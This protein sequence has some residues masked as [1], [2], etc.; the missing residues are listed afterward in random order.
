MENNQEHK[1][2]KIFKNS[3]ENQSVVP[4]ADAWMAIQTYTIGQEESKKRILL[5]YA[6][7]TLLLLLFSGLGLWYYVEN[8]A[9]K[10]LF[11]NTR[12]TIKKNKELSVKTHITTDNNNAS[13]SSLRKHTTVSKIKKSTNL[14][15][16]FRNLNSNN[17]PSLSSLSHE[18]LVE[19]TNNGRKVNLKRPIERE[20]L[21]IEIEDDSTMYGKEEFVYPVAIYYPIG[22]S[23]LET[24]KPK[25][26][27]LNNLSDKIQ[28]ESE[29]KVVALEENLVDKKEIS[30]RDS[31]DFGN[32][33]SLK[34]P[35]ITLGFGNTF[36]FWKINQYFSGS[37]SFFKP[38]NYLYY[39]ENDET[40]IR[41]GVSWKLSKKA[42]FGFIISS[43]KITLKMPFVPQ[44]IFSSSVGSVQPI[45]NLVALNSD[46]FYQSNTV[47]G[48]V[49]IPI[50]Y[51]K[52][53]PTVVPN[54]LDE[55][56]D[57]FPF[58]SHIMTI[59]SLSLT[60]QYD[61]ISKNRKKGK[62]RGYQLYG[63]A[64][65]QVQRQTGYLYSAYNSLYSPSSFYPPI[66][67]SIPLKFSLELNHLENASELVFGLRAGLGFRYQFARKWDFHVEGSGQHSLNNW[68]KSDDIKTFQ[69]ALS[70]QA[71]IN[72]NL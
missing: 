10:E 23:D 11:V 44:P 26:L 65:F 49:N 19:N 4:P 59:T 67:P 46:S 62:R 43:N 41:I 48:D 5:R 36:N 51:F 68:V 20:P 27:A 38:S 57:V 53:L 1:I 14:N 45:A 8:Q 54:K 16:E 18:L 28:K 71:G 33:F 63:L 56:R 2:D 6:S 47:F 25:P 13:Q 31:V 7:L 21:I 70:L 52:E 9:S 60:S 24:I 30:Q 17:F 29:Q 15:R 58:G 22:L 35:I 61:I 37:S 34:H 64:D 72:L 50:S 42:R 66:N 3:L 39:N 55:I 40:Q 12:T 69:R 32:K